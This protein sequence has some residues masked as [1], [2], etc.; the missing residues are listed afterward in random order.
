MGLF[1]GVNESHRKITSGVEKEA[2]KSMISIRFWTNPKGDLPHYSYIFRNTEPFGTE[3]KN[4]ACSR[5]GTMLY[6]ET[7][8]GK[9]AIETSEFQ[10]DI[11]GNMACMKILTRGKKC[12]GKLPPKIT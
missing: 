10:Q 6:L 8:K 11:G 1:G 5:L 9:E 7:K 12:C 4:A 2:D 3:F